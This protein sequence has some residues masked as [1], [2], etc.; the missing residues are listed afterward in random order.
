MKNSNNPSAPLR[1]CGKKFQ[2]LIPASVPSVSYVV[3]K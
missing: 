2:Q 1:P 3:K